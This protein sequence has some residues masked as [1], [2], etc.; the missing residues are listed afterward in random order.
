MKSPFKVVMLL[1]AVGI[2]QQALCPSGHPYNIIEANVNRYA[3]GIICRNAYPNSHA[4]WMRLKAVYGEADAKI[5]MSETYSAFADIIRL[6]NKYW[7]V[8]LV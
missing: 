8:L 3:K 1:L 2:A 6:T 4:M 5:I 7:V